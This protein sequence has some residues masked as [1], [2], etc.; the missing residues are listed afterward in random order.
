M[1]L[2]LV[3]GPASNVVT[4][5]EIYDHL[6]VDL[7][8]S[9][10]EP[11]DANYI[12]GLRDAAEG[13]L[14]GGRGIL[15]RALMTQ[16]WELKVDSFP[17]D[18]FFRRDLFNRYLPNEIQIPLPPLQSV[19]SITYVDPVGATQT[20]ATSVYQVVTNG[21]WPPKI[22]AAY[23]QT[24]PETRDQP[25]AV[26]VRFV[27]GYTSAALVP[28]AIHHAIKLMVAQWYDRR[29]SVVVGQAV[30]ALPFAADAL[31]APYKVATF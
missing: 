28:A 21:E 25:N 31:L 8:G 1:A 29:E 26:T 9:P 6:R 16:T 10:E 5:A 3:T 7:I 17:R 2:E 11:V 20:L 14:D 12:T 15:G 4:M 30:A 24:F 22:V 27:A 23:G 19:T 18:R 13:W